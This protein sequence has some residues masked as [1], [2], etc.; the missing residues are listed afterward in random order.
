MR[1]THSITGTL[2]AVLVTA[3]LASPAA[4]MPIDGPHQGPALEPAP[5]TVIAR[6]QPITDAPS[7]GF[8]WGS[9]GIG[10][11]AGIGAFAIA[12]A[13]AAGMRR[14]HVAQHHSLP[15]N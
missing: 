10:A 9:G 2:A 3:A 14:R 15:S 8:D 13:G 6:P 7:P 5:P 11:A 1:S 4:A 12:L